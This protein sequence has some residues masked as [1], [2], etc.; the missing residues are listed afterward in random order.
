[1]GKKRVSKNKHLAWRTSHSC[2]LMQHSAK[3]WELPKCVVLGRKE[4]SQPLPM[5]PHPRTVA[6]TQKSER[7][8]LSI[9]I[10][11]RNSFQRW[12]VTKANLWFGH[13]KPELDNVMGF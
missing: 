2:V 8:S 9:E 5:C 4:K 3:S 10:C 12:D 7:T 1:M 6:T 11:Q 13:G